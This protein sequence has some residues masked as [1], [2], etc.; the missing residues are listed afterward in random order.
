MADIEQ[1]KEKEG[2]KRINFVL[3]SGYGKLIQE[4]ADATGDTVANICQRA[5]IQH[6]YEIVDSDLLKKLNKKD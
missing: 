3:P 5:T 6:L 1:E 2:S 4:I